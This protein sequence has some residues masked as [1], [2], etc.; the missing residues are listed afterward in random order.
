MKAAGQPE[1]AF[2]IRAGFTKN[3]KDGVG[4]DNTIARS[5]SFAPS[6]ACPQ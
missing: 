4:H 6:A 5:W 2:E 3:V 1:M